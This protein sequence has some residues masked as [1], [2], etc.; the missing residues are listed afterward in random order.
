MS[1]GYAEKLSYI[2]DVGNVGMVEYFDPSHV[3]REKIDQLAIMIK[4]SKHL[5]V[6]TGAGISTSCGIPDFRGP[7]G[8]WTLQREG[9]ALPEASLPFHRAAPSMTHMALVELEKAGI[10]KFVISQNVDGLHLRS[11]IPREKLAEL[12]GNSFMETCPSCGEEYFRDFEVE[13]IGL[14]ETSRRCSVAKCG[15][16]LKDTVLDWE[17]ALPTKEM[18]PA[19]K[20]CK[21]ADIVLCLGTSLQITPACNL[22]LKALRGGGKV[23]IVNLQKT[24][25]DKK[26]SLVI[27]GFVDK[28]IAGVMD[29]LNMQISPFVRIDLFQIILV[30]A[31]SNDKRY[32]NWTLQVASAHGQKAALP[33]I[34][35][36]EISFLDREDYKAAILDKQPFRLK[37][38]T[39]YN[40]AFEMV[41]KLNFSDGCGCSS[42]EIDVPVDFKVSTDCF[43]F[44]KDYIF[45]KLR[46]KAVLESRCGQNAVIERK[47][48]LTPRS[49][50]TTYAI[51][52]NV[53]QYSKACKAALD[54]LSNGDFKKRKASV[55]G[56]GSSRKRS[57]GSSKCKSRSDNIRGHT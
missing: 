29:Q 10:L 4:K 12:H 19:E 14:K 39:A 27:H 5:V 6:F 25:K 21:Q 43:D 49:D 13:T 53:V 18:N 45:Q 1:L 55:T 16:R 56:T 41:L 54:S 9:K 33:F 7:K 51:V 20:H 38:R 32:V 44:D 37:R 36:V 26:A 28:V 52:T 15:T 3:L 24:P 47:T 30:Q 34:K 50:V 35:S 57:K 11:G 40:K 46:D 48:I 8:I 42:L 22:P 31:L 17:D 2:E 23:V